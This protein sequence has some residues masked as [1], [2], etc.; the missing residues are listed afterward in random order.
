MVTS[1]TNGNSIFLPAAGFRMDTFVAMDGYGYY[2]SSSLYE[3]APD[4]AYN[5]YYFYA[6]DMHGGYDRRC[7]G[8][9]VRA[10][11]P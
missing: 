5:L 1:K 2:W 6:G 4:Y 11:C 8:R 7:D 9:T 3:D 10:V